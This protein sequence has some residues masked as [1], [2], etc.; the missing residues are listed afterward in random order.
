LKNTPEGRFI[1]LDFETTSLSPAEGAR[2]IEVSGRE[3]IDGRAGE[4]FLT[5]VD[6]RVRVPAE[7]TRI[8]GITTQ[9]LQGAPKS[10]VVMRESAA[11]IGSSPVV[12]HNVGFNC[13][14]LKHAADAFLEAPTPG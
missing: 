2:M 9:M 3:V 11:F 14:F 7:I 13:E 8:T 10:S 1:I 6:P 5:F 4:E 12:G